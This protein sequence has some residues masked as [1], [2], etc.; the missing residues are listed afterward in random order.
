MTA[1]TAQ[2]LKL[3]LCCTLPF[4]AAQ[5]CGP[6]FFHDVFVRTNHPDL[7]EQFV[8]GRL[9]LLQ[10][11][12]ARSDF[13]VAYRYLNGGTLDAA[14]GKSW[15]PTESMAE[16]DYGK[17]DRPT[18]SV[19]SAPQEPPLDQ[20]TQARKQYP[21]APA[22]PIDPNATINVKSGT[23]EY[24]QSYRNC[25][26]DAFRAATITLQARAAAWGRSSPALADWLRG[27]DAVFRNCSGTATAPAAVGPGSPALL[28]QDR[29]Y[30]TAAAH[31]Y[32]GAYPR[33][34]AEFTAIGKDAGSPWQP[35]GGYLAGRAL[36]RQSF[37]SQP[38]RD[39][40]TVYDL[41]VMKSAG[42]QL[43]TYLAG[44]PPAVWKQA[45]EAQ[46]AL[47]RLRTEPDQR[48]RELATLVGGP[49]HDGNYAQDVLDLLWLM[50]N[51]TPDGLRA[52]PEPWQSMADPAHPGQTR[53]MTPQERD[54]AANAT[55]D[56]A[57]N[58]SQ[59][60][61][62]QADLVDWTITM[63]ALSASAPQHALDQWRAKHTLPWLVA[64]LT[65]MPDRV[66]P[67][68]KLL[69]AAAS[70]PADSPAWQT[71]TYHRARLL[72]AAHRVAD[73]R[74]VLDGFSARLQALPAA[75]REPSTVNA[76]RGLTM[77][78]SADLVEFLSHAPRTLLLAASE[79]ANAVTDCR[80]VMKNPARQYA[81]VAAVDPEQLDTDAAGVLNTQAPLSVW[82]AAAQSASL[83]QQLRT[84][85]AVE[86]WT[87]AVL[88]ND[89]TS[90]QK[91]LSLAPEAL[92]Q[93]AKDSSA[94]AVWMT[95]AR[96]P[97]L[98]PYLNAGTQRAYSYD[99][100]ESYRDNWCYRIDGNPNDTAPPEPATTKPAAGFLSESERQKGAAEAAQLGPMRSVN[101][102]RQITTIV[103]AN[104]GDPQSAEA[105]Y[106]VLRMIRYGCTEPAVAT[107]GPLALAV[108]D[109]QE[110][111]DLLQLK[112]DVGRLMRKYYAT[113]PWTKKAAPFV[114]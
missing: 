92:R 78:S 101:V 1:R 107:P 79:E 104:P 63:Q 86:G 108:P 94:L 89:R 47:V 93:Q 18:A 6:D 48:R 60:E 96:N 85:V 90:A 23:Y 76:V 67:P 22:D 111:K 28:V 75:Q 2:L 61:R 74:A 51:D 84:A 102:G 27:Q 55:R 71:V 91:L 35:L 45:A 110:A 17:V 77:L 7:P 14:E 56:T 29:A 54:A 37:F 26:D 39:G 20:W 19:S 109:S 42:D 21:E 59:T 98:R 100:V 52:Q 53:V 114:G 3:A 105:L 10:T 34:A 32:A 73:A 82:L 88:L 58:G 31:F 68:V 43:R 40:K 62:A 72:L 97:G 4:A 106:L 36:I 49:G 16:Q 103:A 11:G 83:S 9:G 25:A 12:F 38:A 81:C 80:E 30:Q 64:A 66:A 95:L 5:A 41:V 33:A 13:F 15:Q 70:V 112:L 8:Q 57:W 24:D 65:R 44:N 69:Q 99:F 113:S 50:N 87:R 46:L